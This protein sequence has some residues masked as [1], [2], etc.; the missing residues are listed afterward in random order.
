MLI[1]SGKLVIKNIKWNRESAAEEGVRISD[2]PRKMTWD[3][4]EDMEWDDDESDLGI[5][6]SL[7]NEYGVLVDEIKYEYKNVKYIEDEE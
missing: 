4:T 6:D 7:Y 2:L 5:Y 3:I 1:K